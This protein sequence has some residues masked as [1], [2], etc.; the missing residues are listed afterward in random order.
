VAP[1][2]LQKKNFIYTFRH[3]H[4]ETTMC[5]DGHYLKQIPAVELVAGLVICVAKTL[6]QDTCY[7]IT[8][9]RFTIGGTATIEKRIKKH[10]VN[11]VTN[12]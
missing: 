4:V 5:V 3:Q 8:N 2:F 6:D 12:E 11:F 9:I 1:F 10:T 7:W